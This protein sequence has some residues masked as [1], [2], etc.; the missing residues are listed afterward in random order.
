MSDHRK[1]NHFSTE[2]L[3]KM[4]GGSC[5]RILCVTDNVLIAIRYQL[6]SPKQGLRP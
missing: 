2:L 5:M 4:K 3:Q 6:H 1:G